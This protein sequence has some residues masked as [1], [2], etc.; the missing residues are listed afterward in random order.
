MLGNF[1]Q[2]YLKIEKIFKTFETTL[3]KNIRKFSVSS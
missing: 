3:Q 1:E 2:I